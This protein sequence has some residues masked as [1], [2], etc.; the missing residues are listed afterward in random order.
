MKNALA[1]LVVLSCLS[2]AH[3]VEPQI[4]PV[5]E[6]YGKVFQDSRFESMKS[7]FAQARKPSAADLRLGLQWRCYAVL[8]KDSSAGRV[9]SDDIAF[10]KYEDVVMSRQASPAQ[11]LNYK[12]NAGSLYAA[13]RSGRVYGAVASFRVTPEGA[14]L[15]EVALVWPGYPGYN[16]AG[17]RSTAPQGLTKD[18]WRRAGQGSEATVY[19]YARCEPIPQR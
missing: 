17:F 4:E 5:P 18:E 2:A 19:S 16:P 12:E 11:T 7:K 3:A 10:D 8:N 1:A 6:E 15:R 9:D 13:W 14:L